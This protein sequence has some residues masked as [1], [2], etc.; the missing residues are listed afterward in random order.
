MKRS[1]MIQ[2]IRGWFYAN[3]CW[4]FDDDEAESLLITLEEKGM[5][6]PIHEKFVESDYRFGPTGEKVYLKKK[7]HEWEPENETK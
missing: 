2:A 6:P 3:S 4:S 1:E 7:V 5:E